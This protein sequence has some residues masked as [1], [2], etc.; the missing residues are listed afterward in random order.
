M[1]S[2]RISSQGEYE[3]LLV[4]VLV[5]CLVCVCLCVCVC[6]EPNLEPVYGRQVL[7]SYNKSLVPR[8]PHSK[9]DKARAPQ[10]LPCAE[11]LPFPPLSSIYLK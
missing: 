8:A 3:R 6:S 1:I 9:S 7:F 5:G 11:S 4:L 2:G 10:Y